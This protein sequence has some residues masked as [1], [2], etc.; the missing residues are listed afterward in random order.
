M[1]F[2]F[3]I[4]SSLISLIPAQN[5]YNLYS[6]E[7]VLPSIADDETMHYGFWLHIDMP[8]SDGDD[9]DL[10]EDYYSISILDLSAEPAWHSSE[11]N[12]IKV[13][14]VIESFNYEVI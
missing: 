2:K 5:T 10:L 11:Y 6:P 7:I 1:Q 4:L 9:D 13:K 3:L 8:D 12:P 14:E